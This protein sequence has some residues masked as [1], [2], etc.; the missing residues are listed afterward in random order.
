MTPDTTGLIPKVEVNRLSEF[1]ET[2]EQTFET[3]VGSVNTGKSSNEYIIN[4][5]KKQPINLLVIEEAIR[6][7]QHIRQ[8]KVEAFLGGEWKTI[9]EGQSIG[10]KRIQTFEI[11]ETDKI[12]LTLIG[13][14]GK[15]MIKSFTVY[16]SDMLN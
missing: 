5:S 9:A 4:L 12:R 14:E 1:R 7:G 3:P 10:R 15:M 16:K 11:I 8:Y 6:H 2:L 13:E